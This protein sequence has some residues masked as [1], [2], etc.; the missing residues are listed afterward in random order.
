MVSSELLCQGAR[1]STRKASYVLSYSTHSAKLTHLAEQSQTCAPS[2]THYMLSASHQMVYHIRWYSQLHADHC[3]WLF[4]LQHKPD[5]V[6]VLAQHN[7]S[8]RSWPL[9]SSQHRVSYQI[10]RH[11]TATASNKGAVPAGWTSITHT[12]VTRYPAQVKVEWFEKS[13]PILDR[14]AQPQNRIPDGSFPLLML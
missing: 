8:Q 11:L 9:M 14:W 3:T 7:L 13:R 5:R 12:S 4:C 2:H 6:T 10:L 1:I